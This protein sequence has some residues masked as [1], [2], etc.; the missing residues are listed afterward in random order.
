MK[1]TS[2]DYKEV[3][4]DKIRLQ[5]QDGVT[6]KETRLNCKEIEN[7]KTKLKVKKITN[8]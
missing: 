3:T 6:N 5:I 1:Q 7:V 2:Q 4:S 8:E